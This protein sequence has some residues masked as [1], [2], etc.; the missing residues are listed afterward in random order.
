MCQGEISYTLYILMCAVFNIHAYIKLALHIKEFL[1]RTKR[2]KG[3]DL[4]LL[5]EKTSLIFNYCVHS[6]IVG[7]RVCL[8]ESLARIELFLYLTTLVQ[9]FEFL[10]PEGE[11]PPPIEAILA[12]ANGPKP[13]KVR[14]IPRS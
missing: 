9:R 7:R 11:G 1:N 12:T 13:Y 4:S 3:L 2:Y 5:T 8:G 14:A 6:L 10:P